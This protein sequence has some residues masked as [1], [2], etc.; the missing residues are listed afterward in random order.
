MCCHLCSSV[1][2]FQISFKLLAYVDTQFCFNAASF[3]WL[4]FS[5][6]RMAMSPFDSCLHRVYIENLAFN[7]GKQ[8]VVRTVAQITGVPEEH[9]QMRIIRKPH[10]RDIC[11]AIVLASSDDEMN[12]MITSL[13]A[14]PTIYLQH[15]LCSGCIGLNAKQAYWPGGKKLIQAPSLIPPPPPPPPRPF[16]PQ[17]PAGLQAAGSKH[18]PTPPPFPPPSHIVKPPGPTCADHTLDLHTLF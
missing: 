9:V 10:S 4:S 5:F 16:P 2:V 18:A 3:V 1:H 13:N 7:V 11:S 8:L 6:A 14:V 17:V 15:I 12:H